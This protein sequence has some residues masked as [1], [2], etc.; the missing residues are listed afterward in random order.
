MNM[1]YKRPTIYRWK[2]IL[3]LA[4]CLSLVLTVL[5]VPAQALVSHPAS[6]ILSETQANA[7]DTG[8]KLSPAEYL[9]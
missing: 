5:S 7:A 3:A 2:R 4:S 1:K 8:K 6:V 9:S